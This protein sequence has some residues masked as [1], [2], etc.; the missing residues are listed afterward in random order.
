M[1]RRLIP[2]LFLATF[3]I[4]QEPESLLKKTFPMPQMIHHRPPW[5]FFKGRP[6]Y[7][8]LFSDLPQNEVESLTLFFKTD[9]T[10]Q[11]REVPLQPY[12]GRYRFKYDPD[13]HPGKEITYFFVAIM[14]LA[15]SYATP[16]DENGKLVPMIINPIDP[17]K[18][19]ESIAPK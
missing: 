10:I 19:Y 15:G 1:I 7:L 16:V 3:S 5:P 13:L 9:Q 17:A 11:Y 12:R 2:F 14:K 18:Y 6:Y 8:E 4:G